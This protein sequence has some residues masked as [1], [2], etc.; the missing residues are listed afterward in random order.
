MLFV[1]LDILQIASIGGLVSAL[2]SVLVT[3]KK[4]INVF[5]FTGIFLGLSLLY[6]MLFV[7]CK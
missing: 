1:S 7:L 2:L 3:P 6:Y 5:S 4:T